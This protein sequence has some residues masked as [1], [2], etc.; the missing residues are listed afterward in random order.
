MNHME[1]FHHFTSNTASA[2]SVGPSTEK[3]WSKDIPT[4]ALSHRFLM[5]SILAVSALH[6][7][8]LNPA[9]KRTH[10][11]SASAH[12]DRALSL[13]QAEMANPTAE[14]ADALFAF[15]LT[16]VYYAFAAPAPDS[17]PTSRSG[18]FE[19]PE[20]HRAL[21]SAIQC[22]N[23]LRG[24]RSI[25]P[26]VKDFVEAGPLSPLLNMELSSIPSARQFSVPETEAHWSRL[27][28][29]AS[30]T[31]KPGPNEVEDLEIYA[32]A[33]SSLRASSLKVEALAEVEMN[34]PPMWHWAVRLSP[35]FVERLAD[36][37]IVPLVLI[38]HWCVL[39]PQVRHHW[40]IEGWVD[41]TMRE[42]KEV[43]PDEHRAWLEWPERV[44]LA[45]RTGA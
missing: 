17:P 23:L 2:I 36:L 31:A 41:R 16:T 10:Y 15:V 42:I 29:F 32:A 30:T 35:T 43:L 34:T 6:L 40:W 9:Q 7:A 13:A 39:L 44:L 38:A 1:L 22:I 19:E 21:S 4:I 3:L 8:H 33:A 11:A 14:N 12:E 27:L 37:E 5:H 18:N 25:L 26:S 45:R 20:N 24:I 28:Y